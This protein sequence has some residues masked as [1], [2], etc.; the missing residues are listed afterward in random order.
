VS[1]SFH[2]M[3]DSMSVKIFRSV[4]LASLDGSSDTLH[5]TFVHYGGFF[6]LQ[7]DSEGYPSMM[8]GWISHVP[9]RCSVFPAGTAAST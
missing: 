9:P 7:P 8:F 6:A 4:Y 2:N 1:E 5:A 3:P